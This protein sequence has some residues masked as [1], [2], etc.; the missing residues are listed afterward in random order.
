MK[1][2]TLVNIASGFAL[3]LAS[4]A[5]ADDTAGS[6]VNIATDAPLLFGAWGDLVMRDSNLNGL[7]SGPGED[8][9]PATALPIAGSAGHWSFDIWFT[10]KGWD[11]PVQPGVVDGS[12]DT[13][14]GIRGFHHTAPH[15]HEAPDNVLPPIIGGELVNGVSVPAD[16][17][18]GSGA[19]LAAS[20]TVSHGDHSD[21][22]G[23]KANTFAHDPVISPYDAADPNE[24]RQ[25][26]GA[27]IVGA[28]HNDDPSG[29]PR[30][31]YTTLGSTPVQGSLCTFDPHTGMLTVMMGQVDI[32]DAEGGRTGSIAPEFGDDPLAGITVEPMQFEFLGFDPET[33][34][35]LFDGQEM[36]IANADAQ[37]A[38]GGDIGI[39][40][41]SPTGS[42]GMVE[43]ATSFPSLWVIDA[44]G[45][46]APMSHWAQ[47][48]VEQGWF[49]EGLSD[50]QREQ[51][52]WPVISWC[53][54]IDLVEATDGFTQAIDLPATVLLTIQTTDH[55]HDCPVDLNHD[56]ELNFFDVLLFLDLF[57]SGDIAAD[58]A[59]DGELNFFDVLAYLDAFAAGCP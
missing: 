10:N 7:N 34:A 25:L 26:R 54:E 36:L 35:Y 23:V 31:N 50:E 21:W 19:F 14:I 57:T 18:F 5:P 30:K 58:F 16:I 17:R 27:Y 40:R 13:Q 32:L 1:R 4:V 53:V 49:G 42:G 44:G 3:T 43:Y 33:N 46:D 12:H 8:F 15:E 37:V 22:Y 48:F 52:A 55:D 51:I 47:Q 56:S 59:Q 41:M 45:V 24:E 28:R 29:P 11:M 20:S 38:I 2:S 39:V 6:T 9:N